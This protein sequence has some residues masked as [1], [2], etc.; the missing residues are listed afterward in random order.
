[1]GSLAPKP[2]FCRPRAAHWSLTPDIRTDGLEGAPSATLCEL[3]REAGGMQDALD[4]TKMTAF[5]ADNDLESGTDG[6]SNSRGKR[7]PKANACDV[8]GARADHEFQAGFVSGEKTFENGRAN[9][10]RGP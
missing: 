10:C 4:L 1:M 8:F 5:M 2:A 9:V 6:E 3:V 7:I